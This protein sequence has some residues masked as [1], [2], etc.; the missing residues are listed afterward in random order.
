MKK[1]TKCGVEKNLAEFS[2]DKTRKDGLRSHCKDCIKEYQKNN[3]EH[4]AKKQKEWRKTN[5]EYNREYHKQ[6]YEDNIEKLC[7][8]QRDYHKNNIEN[9]HKQ[10]KIYNKNNVDKK[11]KYDKEYRK[12]NTEKLRK[13]QRAYQYKRRNNN[14]LFKLISNIRHR[15]GNSI[16]NGGF[17][18]SSRTA[19]ILG[20]TFEEFQIH[21]EN[22]F[23]DGMT[24]VNYGLWHLDH[25][26]P[27]SMAESEDHLL[28]LN[29][30]T[31]FQPLWAEENIRKSNKVIDNQPNTN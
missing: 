8:K 31:N 25:I 7:K 21:I 20:C 12:N 1:C 26:Y 23:T 30:Y 2:K 10:K 27:V 15:I 14:I 29:H 4:I 13:K 18:K 19:S 17:K 3:A 22:Q 28:Q 6:Y 9:I 16:K 5:L 24:W 11:S